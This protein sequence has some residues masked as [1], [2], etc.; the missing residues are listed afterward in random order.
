M[1]DVK[2]YLQDMLSAFESIELFVG[3]MT[4]AEFVEDD[5]T[6]SAVIRKFEVVGEAAKGV[7]EEF[8]EGYSDVPW[9]EMAGMRDRLIHLYFGVDY[10]LVWS[11]IKEHLPELTKVLNQILDELP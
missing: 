6:S 5:K 1:R 4:Y 2:L 11:A 3:D 7:S 8:R 10:E 9:R